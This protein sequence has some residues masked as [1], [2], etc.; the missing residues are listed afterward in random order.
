MMKLA[1]MNAYSLPEGSRVTPSTLRTG[2]VFF[3]NRK[4]MDHRE[5]TRVRQLIHRNIAKTGHFEA[6][7]E[8]L[9]AFIFMAIQPLF[10]KKFGFFFF[11]ADNA[12]VFVMFIGYII[13]LL[14]MFHKPSGK[15][16]V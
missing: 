2:R 1:P 6:H 3:N 10:E 4:L 15:T 13:I 14:R 12:C 9:D 16:S 8:L 7:K 5:L 11:D